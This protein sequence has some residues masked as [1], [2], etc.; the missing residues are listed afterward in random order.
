MFGIQGTWWCD[1][2]CGGH[3]QPHTYGLSFVVHMTSLMGWLCLLGEAYL[4]K[5]STFL[6]S[7]KPGVSTIF[8]TVP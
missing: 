5:H 2:G 8:S 4:G 3:G 7:L 1:V 6:A